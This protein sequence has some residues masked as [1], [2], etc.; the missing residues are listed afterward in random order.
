MGVEDARPMPLIVST[1][2][3]TFSAG[4]EMETMRKWTVA[5][6]LLACAPAFADDDAAFKAKVDDFVKTYVNAINSQNVDG[7]IATYAPDGVLV[8]ADGRVEHAQDHPAGLKAF[9]A[10]GL[11]EEAKV[12]EAH[13]FG[14]AGYAIGT[15]EYANAAK[16]ILVRGT[17]SAAY[18]L[19]GDK[20]RTK[21]LMG[22][23]PPAPVKQ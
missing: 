15:F 8:Y 1:A 2:H 21:L 10:M 12:T 7:V 6:A 20:I 4:L 5:A 18:A 23:I 19:D 22:S 3:E 9:F 16:Q 11:H 14:D 17:W 13:R